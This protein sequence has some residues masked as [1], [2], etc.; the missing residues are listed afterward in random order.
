[1]IWIFYST[2][3]FLHSLIQTY[4]ALYEALKVVLAGAFF[5]ASRRGS[6]YIAEVIV[7]SL[8]LKARIGDNDEAFDWLHH[9][10]STHVPIPITSSHHDS[11][12]DP[13]ALK[14]ILWDSIWPSGIS[15]PRDVQIATRKPRGRYWYG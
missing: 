9:Y 5:E 15:A 2:Y 4:P 13:Y 3:N 6:K 8:T 14:T 10:L 1:M 12:I 7:D 11:L